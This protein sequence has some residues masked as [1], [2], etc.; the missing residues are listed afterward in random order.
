MDAVG[1]VVN[2][3]ANAQ[4]FFNKTEVSYCLDE[5]NESVAGIVSLAELGSFVD[6]A[7]V[8]RPV[9]LNFTRISATEMVD[10]CFVTGAGKIFDYATGSNWRLE[11]G[12]YV[13]Q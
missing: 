1:C 2:A 11:N 7:T 9:I 3:P 6:G 5:A 13:Q 12:A 4:S 10:D 8:N